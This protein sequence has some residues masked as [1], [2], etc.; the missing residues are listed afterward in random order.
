[1]PVSRDSTIKAYKIYSGALANLEVED[2]EDIYASEEIY[3]SST[4][5]TLT[6][7]TINGTD[8]AVASEGTV[9]NETIILKSPHI[10]TLRL[11]AAGACHV[12]VSA[13]RLPRDNF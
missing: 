7:E 9:T 6:V 12:T 13:K 8:T 5:G 10:Q 2:I 11:T 4:G 1:M 3:I